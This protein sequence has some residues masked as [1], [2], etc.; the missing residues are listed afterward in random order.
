MRF[1]NYIA[2]LEM[3]N[4]EAETAL[5]L[6]GA[7]TAAEVKTAWKKAAMINHPDKG[8]S[9]EKMKAVNVAYDKLKNGGGG[10]S[11]KFDWAKSNEKYNRYHDIVLDDLKNRF[12]PKKFEDFFKSYFNDEFTTD[13]KWSK[14]PNYGGANFANISVKFSNN[15]GTVAF[16]FSV[17]VNL[18]EVVHPKAQLGGDSITYDMSITASG[19]ANSKKQKMSRR[20]WGYSNSIKVLSDPSM[21]FPIAKMKKIVKDG[22]KTGP[23]KLKRADMMKAISNVAKGVNFSDGYIITSKDGGSFYTERGVFMRV[24]YWSFYPI[25]NERRHSK[26]GKLIGF[27]YDLSHG[28]LFSFPEDTTTLELFAS[29][30][31]SKSSQVISAA[32]KLKGK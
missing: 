23:I 19:F 20:D 18:I 30:H 13:I 7:Y 12:K 29:I 17:S 2:L 10:S 16:D 28:G 14:I 21:T 25:T 26:T 1:K 24:P 6:T 8:G 5:G 11:G 22:Q 32:K 4:Q 9:L 3:S 15:N 27:K 31:K